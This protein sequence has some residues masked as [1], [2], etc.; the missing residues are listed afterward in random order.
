M[1]ANDFDTEG[2]LVLPDLFDAAFIESVRLQALENYKELR[3]FLTA[4]NKVLGIGAQ[5]VQPN[6]LLKF[7]DV[8]SSSYHM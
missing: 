3:D 7:S 4:H 5:N 6:K 8:L 2:L 1:S